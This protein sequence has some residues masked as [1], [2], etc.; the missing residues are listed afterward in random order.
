MASERIANKTDLATADLEAMAD[1][2][3]EKSGVLDAL[4]F[5]DYAERAVERILCTAELGAV[6]GLDELPYE[7]FRCWPIEGLLNFFILYRELADG[8]EIARVLL[9]NQ[10]LS[11]LF[12]QRP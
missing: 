4:R 7:D 5:V 9:T 6:I 12:R 3:L 8:I 1:A 10:D 2:L 11:T